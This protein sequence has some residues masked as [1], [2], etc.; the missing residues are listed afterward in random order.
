M[1]DQDTLHSLLPYL[2]FLIVA[3]ML[4]RRTRRPRVFR[5]ARLW[6][7]PA[8]FL[9]IAALYVTG[10]VKMGPTLRSVDWAIIAAAALLG[11]AVG[12]LRAHFIHLTRRPSDGLIETRLSIWGVIFILLWIGGRQYVRQ[13]GWVDAGAQFG[14]YTDAGLSLALGLLVANAIV[15]TRRCQALMAE[16]KP[17]SA[18]VPGNAV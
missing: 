8:I 11:A 18:N 16:A 14:V 1:S 15:L 6:I 7:A 2:P 4:I 13:S 12:A 5:P 10:A 17:A 3:V 9:V